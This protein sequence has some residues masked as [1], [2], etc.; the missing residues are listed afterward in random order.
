[1]R[2]GQIIGRHGDGI[3]NFPRWGGRREICLFSGERAL[4]DPMAADPFVGVLRRSPPPIGAVDWRPVIYSRRPT[5][6]GDLPTSRIPSLLPGPPPLAAAAIRK[7][8]PR[9]GRLLQL[10]RR[11]P[12]GAGGEQRRSNESPLTG[13]RMQICPNSRRAGSCI[14]TPSR[15][16]PY[17]KTNSSSDPQQ[18][19]RGPPELVSSGRVFDTIYPLREKATRDTLGNRPVF[20]GAP[21]L[22][23][24][25]RSVRHAGVVILGR[26]YFTRVRSRGKGREA[27]SIPHRPFRLPLVGEGGALI[28]IR[29]GA[30]SRRFFRVRHPVSPSAPGGKYWAQRPEQRPPEV[31]AAKHPSSRGYRRAERATRPG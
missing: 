22:G 10:W 19:K 27:G 8:L 3:Y 7:N 17:R 15:T 9:D 6:G 24:G 1:M 23:N 11:R 26:R 29:G 2:P 13:E 30:C 25:N 20:V 4:A 12:S 18:L 16:R 5:I 21:A 31:G 14:V 28:G